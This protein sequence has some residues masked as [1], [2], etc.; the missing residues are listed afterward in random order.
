M[1]EVELKENVLWKFDKVRQSVAAVKRDYQAE[2][3]PRK[4]EEF[5]FERV[6]TD[7]EMVNL[8]R[9]N[10]PKAMEDKS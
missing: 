10:V 9:G 1:E 3:M 2:P 6:F 5:T 7:S 8:R 4:W